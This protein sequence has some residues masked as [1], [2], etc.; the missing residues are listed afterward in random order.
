MALI[1]LIATIVIAL[2]LTLIIEIIVAL[3]LGYKKKE[4]L[5]AIIGVNLVTN[6]VLNF[7]I[8]SNAQIKLFDYNIYSILFLEVVVVIIEFLLLWFIFRKERNKMLVLSITMNAASFMVGVIL[9]GLP[10]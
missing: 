2:V 1:E 9:F 7:L 3:L 6:P 8:Q 4:Y 10:K 5:L